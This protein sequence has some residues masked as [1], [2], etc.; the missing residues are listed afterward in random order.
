VQRNFERV[1]NERIFF[2]CFEWLSLQLSRVKLSSRGF[3]FCF[4][5]RSLSDRGVRSRLHIPVANSLVIGWCLA[6]IRP[7][8]TMASEHPE[9]PS[10]QPLLRNF[11]IDIDTQREGRKTVSL[12]S[13][14]DGEESGDEFEQLNKRPGFW[15]R[16][17]MSIR[18]R[19]G[20]LVKRDDDRLRVGREEKRGL[21]R[22]RWRKRLCLV[23]PVVILSVL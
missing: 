1:R 4:F 10:A 7:V 18:R 16:L 19:N 5:V 11:D 20:E 22:Y 17:R 21:K 12:R 2:F 23:I 9:S 14:E 13:L 8:L 15:Q 3:S 6:S